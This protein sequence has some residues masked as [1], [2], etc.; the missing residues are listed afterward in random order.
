MSV[1]KY[2]KEL[3]SYEEYAFSLAELIKA[4]DKTEISLKRELSR[5]VEKR[6]I[7]N[8]RKGF[9][10]IIPPRY[11]NQGQLPVQLY[12]EKLFIFLKRNYYL[13]FYSA[14]K[15]H[16]AGHQ[17][18]QRDYIITSYPSILD[19]KK[20]SIDINFCAISNWPNNNI[21][22][23]KSDAEYFK[24]SSP[25]LTFVDLIHHKAKLG[26]LNRVFT[27]LQELT[28]EITQQDLSDLLNWYPY[29]STLQRFGYLLELLQAD[30]VIIEQLHAHIRTHNYYPILLDHKA[31]QKAGA[32]DNKW[33]VAVNIKLESD[34]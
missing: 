22:E 3:Q 12:I 25:V 21:L 15:F 17:Q 14:A 4:V 10:L 34:L 11:S 13:G 30:K 1:S 28:E 6:E 29:M 19:I 31:G 24:I 18:I 23:K 9:Y 27:V 8:L 16:G 7:L 2:I 33:K 20:N 26:G 5:L 32:V